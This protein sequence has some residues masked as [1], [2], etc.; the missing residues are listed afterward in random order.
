MPIIF[1]ERSCA[2]TLRAVARHPASRWGENA[3][4][5]AAGTA[6]LDSFNFDTCARTAG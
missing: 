2:R 5:T 4:T 6:V 1:E 3:S